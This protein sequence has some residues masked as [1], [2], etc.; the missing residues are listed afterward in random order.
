[1]TY[2]AAGKWRDPGTRAEFVV[3]ETPD[4]VPLHGAYYTPEVGRPHD[5][6][7]LAYHGSGGNFYSGACGIIAPGVTS[8]GYAALALNL[9][10]HDRAHDRSLFEPCATDITTAVALLRER[11]FRRI[12]MFGHSLA[13]TQMTY[14]LANQPDPEVCGAILS[15]G[16]WDLA[17]DKW[18]SWSKLSDD[19]R[20]A[21]EAQLAACRELIATGHGD[22]LLVLP[23]WNPDPAR[24]NPEHYRAI[25]AKT[26]VNYYGPESNCRLARWIGSVRV[27]LLI[28]THTVV[29][30]FATPE[31]A[32]KI[33]AGATAAPFVDFVNIEGS[34][35]F[36]R[37]FEQQLIGVVADWLDKVRSSTAAAAR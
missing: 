15:G 2:P 30:T 11:G 5:L 29:D 14:Y 25:S 34:G 10:D 27:P 17:G 19:P 35:H 3:A 12:V 24:H 37:G 13:P 28:L 32:E 22:D 36:F 9:R 21:F 31:M 20:G 23:H 26:F 16:H 7:L 1:M 8:R 18:T 4:G 6:A 33:R